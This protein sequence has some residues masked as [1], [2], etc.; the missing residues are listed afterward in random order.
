MPDRFSSEYV[1]IVTMGSRNRAITVTFWNT[2][3]ITC[4]L[5]FSGWAPPIMPACIACRMNA[6]RMN[7]KKNP[8]NAAKQ[9]ITM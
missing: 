8:Y 7:E 3:L 5:T 6:S 1:R 4:W 9:P 2:G